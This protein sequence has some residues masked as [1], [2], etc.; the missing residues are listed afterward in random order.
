V[1]EEVRPKDKRKNLQTFAMVFDRGV[2]GPQR[3]L[4]GGGGR[5]TYTGQVSISHRSTQ[6]RR[7]LLGGRY[8]EGGGKGS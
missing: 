3:H 5:R 8:K 7:L 6:K 1:A 2:P 4:G